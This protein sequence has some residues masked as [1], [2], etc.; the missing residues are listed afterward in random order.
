MLPQRQF[1]V[2]T[3]GTRFKNQ[4]STRDFTNKKKEKV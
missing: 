4:T 3:G 1:P 2:T